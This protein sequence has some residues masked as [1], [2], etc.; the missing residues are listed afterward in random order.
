MN[1][2]PPDSRRAVDRRF[3]RR[4]RARSPFG[5]ARTAPPGRRGAIGRRRRLA[6]RAG[7]WCQLRTCARSRPRLCISQKVTTELAVVPVAVGR[8]RPAPYSIVLCLAHTCPVPVIGETPPPP[9]LCSPLAC[10]W[11]PRDPPARSRLEL[12]LELPRCRLGRSVGS[13]ACRA[14]RP[15]VLGVVWVRRREPDAALVAPL[16][17]GHAALPQS[18]NTVHSSSS[19]RRAS[20]VVCILGRRNRRLERRPHR[21]LPL[22]FS[23]QSR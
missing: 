16:R 3:D 5:L 1:R 4:R 9:G 8:Q 17:L 11:C 15:V 7:W 20:S 23:G 10:S 19:P 12:K 18:S 21:R 14:A 2:H 13:D 6:A 22:R